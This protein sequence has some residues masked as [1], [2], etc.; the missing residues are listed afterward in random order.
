VVYVF[1]E[2]PKKTGLDEIYVPTRTKVTLRGEE[3]TLNGRTY[4]KQKDGFDLVETN[5]E[6]EFPIYHSLA[7]LATFLDLPD[8]PRKEVHYSSKG[9]HIPEKR[10]KS[11]D[12]ILRVIQPSNQWRNTIS[13][14]R[15]SHLDSS[16]EKWFNY[17]AEF[18]NEDDDGENGLP[19]LSIVRFY[20]YY[21]SAEGYT[22]HTEREYLIQ[23]HVPSEND[24]LGEDVKRLEDILKKDYIHSAVISGGR[25][26][27]NHTDNK[28][29]YTLE[30]VTKE[31]E[32]KSALITLVKTHP[33]W[34]DKPLTLFER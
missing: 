27:Y 2:E 19:L 3:L 23:L 24:F 1:A 13:L 6:E 20:A 17:T 4:T 9:R 18:K 31:P 7:V 21:D 25:T 16:H 26:A 5:F 11:E 28:G 32:V 14:L 12:Q 33:E 8:D 22:P 30:E 15:H 34:K 10:E 29:F